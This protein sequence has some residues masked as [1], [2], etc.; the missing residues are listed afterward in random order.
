MLEIRDKGPLKEYVLDDGDPV[1]AS[2]EEIRP[3]VLSILLGSRSFTVD[4][5]ETGEAYEVVS[6]DGLRHLISVS[7]TRDRP[8]AAES[9]SSK[10]PATVRAHIPGKVVTLLIELGALVELGQGLIVV[11]AMKMQ[12]AVKSPKAGTV[13]KI[14][15][16]PGA[17][18]AAGEALLVVE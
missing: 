7:D 16:A 1:S 18:V 3:G 2:I 9:E 14:L 6:S 11:E 4:V 8:G 10:G 5:V 13:I 12:N 17:T 15:T